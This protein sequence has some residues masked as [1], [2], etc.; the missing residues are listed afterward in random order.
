[1]WTTAVV[2]PAVSAGPWVQG[3]M[4]FSSDGLH[5]YFVAKGVLTEGGAC[6][7]AIGWKT[8]VPGH[9]GLGSVVYSATSRG[10]CGLTGA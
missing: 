7:K 1:M 10:S 2:D 5:V 6:E 4:A 3:V 9:D 8:A